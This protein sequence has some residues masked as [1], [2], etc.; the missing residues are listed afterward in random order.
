ME[1]ITNNQ[2]RDFLYGYE[3]PETVLQSDFDYL[4]DDETTDGFI[5]YRGCY[6]HLSEF[7]RLTDNTGIPGDWSGYLSDSAF[8]GVLVRVSRDGEQYQI[9]TFIS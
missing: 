6:Y 4:D 5:K 7:M 3:I 8:S 9:A 2:W 1:I